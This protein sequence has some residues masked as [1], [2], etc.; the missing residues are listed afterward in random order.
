MAVGVN[1]CELAAPAESMAD[2]EIEKHCTGEHI[3]GI[4][5]LHKPIV[6]AELAAWATK[7]SHHWRKIMMFG[8]T[9]CLEGQTVTFGRLLRAQSTCL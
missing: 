1:E 9:S 8:Q 7:Q 5:F 4:E 6:I 3:S 2:S